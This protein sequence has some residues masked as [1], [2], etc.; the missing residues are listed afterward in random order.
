MFDLGH[1]VMTSGVSNWIQGNPSRIISLSKILNRHK[2]GDWGDVCDEDKQANNN[3]LKHDLRVLSSYLVDG[4]KLWV[5]TE[6][7][8]SVTTVLFPSEY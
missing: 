1:Q 4:E 7:D 2:S 8:R 5:I 3:A 6:W